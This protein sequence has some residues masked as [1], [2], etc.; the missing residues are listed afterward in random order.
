MN[1]L[2]ELKVGDKVILRL[3]G[4]SNRSALAEVFRITKNYI[5]LS[6]SD[7]KYRKSDGM[8]AGDRGYHPPRIAEWSF[9][10][11][12][13]I[14]NAGKLRRVEDCDFSKLDPITIS[15]ILVLIGGC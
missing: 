8:A 1:W 10:A 2:N 6:G 12:V 14:V 15:K 13:E 7:R 5:I 4:R 11:Q 3:A 9:S